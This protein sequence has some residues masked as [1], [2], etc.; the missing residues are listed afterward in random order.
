M[1]GWMSGYENI[2]MWS[3]CMVVC[4]MIAG[5]NSV[6]FSVLICTWWYVY[7]IPFLKHMNPCTNFLLAMLL[8]QEKR[9][10]SVFN[11]IQSL[12]IHCSLKVMTFSN[13]DRLHTIAPTQVM[14]SHILESR[15]S[16]IFPTALSNLVVSTLFY[17]MYL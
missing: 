9:S 14:W 5:F 1:N 17:M 10:F 11:N 16:K 13:V 7:S 12:K 2:H 4:N 3:C 8:H 6:S 15:Q